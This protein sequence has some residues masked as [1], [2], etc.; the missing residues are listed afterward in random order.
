MSN[1]LNRR[2]DSSAEFCERTHRQLT[3]QNCAQA[4]VKEGSTLEGVYTLF[5]KPRDS[6]SFDSMRIRIASP[7]KDPV[8]VMRRS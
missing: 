6:V 7:E 2:T 8:M 1:W 4:T 5:E 3:T